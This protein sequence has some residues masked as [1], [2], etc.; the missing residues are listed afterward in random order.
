MIVLIVERATPGMRGEL[1]RWLLE[2]KSGVFVGRISAMVREQLWDLVEKR[3]PR[4]G[5]AM[6]IQQSNNDQGYE[7]RSIGEGSRSLVDFEGI[8]LVERP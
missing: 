8:W 3:L 2:P 4:D 7:I 5:A 1:S 6:M